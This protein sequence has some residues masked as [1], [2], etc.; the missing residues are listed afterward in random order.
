MASK[1]GHS[2]V[3]VRTLFTQALQASFLIKGFRQDDGIQRYFIQLL[4]TIKQK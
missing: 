3:E 4:S 2:L 1:F